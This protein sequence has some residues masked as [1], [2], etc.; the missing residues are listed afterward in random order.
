MTTQEATT[1]FGP[2]AS[3]ESQLG[4]RFWETLLAMVAFRNDQYSTS[5]VVS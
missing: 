3:A 4:G 5:G 2:T 1:K